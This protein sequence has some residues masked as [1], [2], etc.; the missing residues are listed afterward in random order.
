MC[1][2]E[3]RRFWTGTG[4]AGF[5]DRERDVPTKAG[6]RQAHG[7]PYPSASTFSQF[8][9]LP[10]VL[11]LRLLPSVRAENSVIYFVQQRINC[12]FLCIDAARHCTSSS[13]DEKI[14]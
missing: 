6:V 2:R 7:P 8:S 14:S 13:P 1:E 9:G 3:T 12:D 10:L 4:R 11:V 5:P